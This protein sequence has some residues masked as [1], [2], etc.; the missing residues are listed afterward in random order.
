MKQKYDVISQISAN[1]DNEIPYGRQHYHIKK[2]KS[3][4]NLHDNTLLD[5]MHYLI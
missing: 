2:V 4:Y 1:L 3:N 5:C